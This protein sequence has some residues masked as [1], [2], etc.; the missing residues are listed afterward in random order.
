[1]EEKGLI[2]DKNGRL[3]YINMF[4]AKCLGEK[5]LFP[6]CSKYNKVC[7]YECKGLCRDSC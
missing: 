5:Y 2:V 6:K 4:K 1:M 3:V 7:T